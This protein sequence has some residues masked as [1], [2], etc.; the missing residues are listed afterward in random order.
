MDK[1]SQTVLGYQLPPVS[2]WTLDTI[3][4]LVTVKRNWIL[5]V[6]IPFDGVL[7]VFGGAIVLDPMGIL[8]GVRG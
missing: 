6:N 1:I 5:L 2:G 7:G 3:L 4:R 8:P